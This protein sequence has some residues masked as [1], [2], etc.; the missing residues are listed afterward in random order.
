MYTR[1][2]ASIPRRH[3]GHNRREWPHGTQAHRWPHGMH[4]I[5]LSSVKHRTQRFSANESSVF[6]LDVGAAFVADDSICFACA[7]TAVDVAALFSLLGDSED[8]VSSTSV[9]LE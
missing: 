6:L 4:A 1:T 9:S 8:V 2:K 5:R 7:S 3:I